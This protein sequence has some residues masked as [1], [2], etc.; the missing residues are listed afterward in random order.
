MELSSLFGVHDNAYV[1]LLM[2]GDSYLPG[3]YTSVHSVA[4]TNPEADLVIM[5]T[6][7]VSQ[8]AINL[9]NNVVNDPHL[10]IVKVDYI[11]FETLPLKTEKQNKLYKSWKSVSYTKWNML[12]LPYEKVLFLDADVIVT[13][14]IDHLFEM[15]C[16]AAPFNNAF[17]KPYGHINNYTNGKKGSDGYLLHGETI[18]RKEINKMLYDGG[19]V[20]VASTI[21]LEPNKEHYFRY[22]RTMQKLLPFGFPHCHSMVDEQSIVY[23]YTFILGKTWSNIHHRY[24]LIA[25]KKDGYLSKDIV[26][27]VIHYFSDVK[28]WNLKYNEYED[29]ISWYK[30]AADAIKETK[31][32]STDL[33]LTLDSVLKASKAQDTFIQK[34]AG[35]KI[36]ILDINDLNM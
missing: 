35:K 36:N 21:L 17:A 18:N 20:L 25:W 14:N 9:L 15:K 1:W 6:N 28:P 2:K 16:P 5:V 26:P 7:D 4:R 8:N 11:E 12:L 10:H 31:I 34:F 27:D 23:F 22:I 30:M 29:V 32:K 24:N 3:V 33:N 13:K 19:V